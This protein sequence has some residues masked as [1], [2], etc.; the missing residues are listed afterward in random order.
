MFRKRPAADQI[1][2]FGQY[3]TGTT[4]LFYKLLDAMPE[5]TRTYYE[6]KSCTPPPKAHEPALAKVILAL[7]EGSAAVDY[8]AFLRF[9][10][11]IL[12]LRDP[13]DRIVSGA[14]F[15][16][17]QS[18]GIYDN[19]DAVARIVEL[20][21]RKEADPASMP[22]SVLLDEVLRLANGT[23]TDY[24]IDELARHHEWIFEFEGRMGEHLQLKYEDFV[25]GRVSTLETFLDRSL[26][27]SGQVD[28]AH[29]HV[30]RTKGAGDWKNWFT[31]EDV[32]RF[33]NVCNT[34]L[35]R[36]GYPL[37]WT[38]SQEPIV[39]PAHASEYVRR[40]IAKRKAETR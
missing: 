15:I 6:P 16:I 34:Y 32:D 39:R 10:K 31:A 23:S 1:A 7:Y 25:A 26:D 24:V 9:P 20:L 40:A 29:S 27:V 22:I 5:K 30:A 12:L 17:Q 37:D 36:Y 11:R 4:A 33:S 2:I 28:S 13:R 18:P 3:K 14:L 8:D 21:H 35:K 19:P 38:T